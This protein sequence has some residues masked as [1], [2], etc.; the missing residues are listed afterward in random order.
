M[1]RFNLAKRIEEAQSGD[2]DAQFD[3][4]YRYENG[5]ELEVN[6]EEVRRWYIRP[7]LWRI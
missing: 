7:S 6:K 3:L 4:G 2:V 5:Y 1:K